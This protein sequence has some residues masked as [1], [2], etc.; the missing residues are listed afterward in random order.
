MSNRNSGHRVLHFLVET[1]SVRAYVTFLLAVVV[2]FGM[3][4]AF[5]TPGENGF[6]HIGEEP[7]G[8]LFNNKWF[9][10]IYFSVVTISSLGY[11][12]IYPVGISRIL[13][14]LEV[15]I[16]VAI[17]G[18]IIAKLTSRRIAFRIARLSRSNMEKYLE[19]STR[20]ISNL[21]DFFE[22]MLIAVGERYQSTPRRPQSA[23][24]ESVPDEGATNG[25]SE[26]EAG[27]NNEGEDTDIEK[28]S[29]ALESL[30]IEYKKL[31]DYLS[32]ERESGDF[33]QV[34]P[35]QSLLNA[36]KAAEMATFSL[37]QLLVTVPKSKWI[38]S[39]NRRR[40]WAI[41][42]YLRHVC[43]ELESPAAGL[44]RE[45]AVN[46]LRQYCETLPLSYHPSPRNPDDMQP[47]HVPL[48]DGVEP[49][50]D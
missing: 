21:G 1:V 26:C 15:L 2:L 46:A 24:D 48:G 33:F 38:S 40:I 5:L 11:G 4:Y 28:F 12:D 44:Q 19:T 16:G 20:Q 47:S 41:A 22:K 34:A 7:D 42:E 50:V 30:S 27:G 25:K 18:I 37:M 36:T 39:V 35:K 17:L 13:T 10:G 29:T 43:N 6:F 49:S 31:G 3:I 32:E 8:T 9:N 23:P 14:S 45:H